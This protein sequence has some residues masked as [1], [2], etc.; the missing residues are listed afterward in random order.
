MINNEISVGAMA[1]VLALSR[2]FTEVTTLPGTEPVFGMQRF[3]VTVLCFL[4]T[5]AVYLPLAVTVRRLGGGSPIDAVAGGS[6][7]LSGF[8]GV[9][10]SGYL[11]ICAAETG[12]RAFHYT[13][14]TVFDQAPSYLFFFL[15]G[16][17]L[18]YSVYK[19]IEASSRTAVLTAA[20]L[21]L[22]LVLMFA[23]L[24]P[25]IKPGRLY[26]A[27]TDDEDTLWREVMTEFSYGSEYIV[28]ALLCGNVRGKPERAIP[29]YLGLSCGIMLLMTFL[30]LT[31]FGR[32]ASRLG[33]PFYSL[34]SIADITLLHRI[35]GI[36]TMIWVAAGILRLAFFAFAFRSTVRSC[37]APGRAADIAAFVFCAAAL[38]LSRLASAYPE[39]YEPAGRICRSGIPLAFIAAFIPLAAVICTKKR[40]TRAK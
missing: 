5:A 6:K 3:T 18:L 19:G 16:A 14:G 1:A 28:F 34:S 24:I 2:I 29:I 17:A 21:V 4:L 35:N 32:L 23:T 26:P 38:G 13:A 30:Y 36:D 37:F 39:I 40:R 7:V 25:E 33:F 20:G 9:L 22:L 15:T 10:I 27:F 31:V 12:M 8:A 11:L